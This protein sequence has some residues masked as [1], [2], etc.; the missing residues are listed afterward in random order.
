MKRI[1]P[2]LFFAAVVIVVAAHIAQ[3]QITLI[4]D[5]HAI[6]SNQGCTGIGTN[7]Y[8]NAQ[9]CYDSSSSGNMNVYRRDTNGNWTIINNGTSSFTTLTVSGAATFGSIP[10]PGAIGG[11]TPAAGTFTTLNATS[12]PA[13]G[14]IG[15]T[16]PA[17]GTFTTLTATS[18]ADKALNVSNGGHISNPIGTGT[19][20]TSGTGS[21]TAGGTDS[22]FTCTG[23]TSPVTVTFGTS[24]A[25]APSCGCS[26][27]TSAT[28]I[29]A[30]PGTGTIVVTTTATDSFSC[31][32]IGH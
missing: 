13:L 3:S 32:C 29:K 12:A 24:F 9:L 14:A 5:L 8:G 16:T 7:Q 4:Q 30:V 21:I 11:T 19:P 20:P 6:V 10:S 23:G 18:S 17:A 28:A 27:I 31:V 15:G 2:S 25:V 26:D 22:A 1:L